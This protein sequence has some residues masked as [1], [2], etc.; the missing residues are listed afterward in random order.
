MCA[1]RRIPDQSDD[2]LN[3]F[4]VHK[5]HAA[6][7]W[8]CPELRIFATF[9]REYQFDELEPVLERKLKCIFIGCFDGALQQAH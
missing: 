5:C 3:V 7:N 2:C 8:I 6:A 4:C 1:A 9:K